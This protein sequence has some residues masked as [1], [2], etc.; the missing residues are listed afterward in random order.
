MARRPQHGGLHEE[1]ASYATGAAPWKTAE[2]EYH[3]LKLDAGGRVVI[4]AELRRAMEVEPGERLVAFLEDG[5]LRV[6]G[7]KVGIRKAQEYVRSIVPE[8]VSLV[9]ELIAERIREAEEEERDD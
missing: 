6:V 5:E 8:D 1:A 4:P 7:I 2:P 3:Q 9:D